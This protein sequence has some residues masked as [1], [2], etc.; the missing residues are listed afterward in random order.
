MNPKRLA[1]LASG[2]LHRGLA[3]SHPSL[4]RGRVWCHTCGHTQAVDSARC[5][6]V[7]WPEHCG[8]TMSVDAPT[9]RRTKE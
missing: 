8:Q 6:A 3:A 1:D 7:G 5:L 9:T 2:T 4:K